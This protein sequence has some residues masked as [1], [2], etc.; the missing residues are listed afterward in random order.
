MLLNKVNEDDF[1]L[2]FPIPRRDL[3][4]ILPTRSVP[5]IKHLAKLWL[6][7]ISMDEREVWIKEIEGKFLRNIQDTPNGHPKKRDVID[8]AWEA[9]RSN[10]VKIVSD[11]VKDYCTKRIKHNKIEPF[12]GYGNHIDELE[13]MIN[14]YMEDYAGEV[15]RYGFSKVP[16]RSILNYL[17]KHSFISPAEYNNHESKLKD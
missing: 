2:E 7:S 8:Y 10:L 11:V 3:V 1:L 15:E 12:R 9:N 16:K 5:L 6:Y 14:D 17:R 4:K 13:E